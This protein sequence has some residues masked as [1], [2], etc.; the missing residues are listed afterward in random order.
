MDDYDQTTCSEQRATNRVRIK[1]FF[2]QKY[3]ENS[4]WKNHQLKYKQ[5]ILYISSFKGQLHNSIVLFGRSG[6]RP[7]NAKHGTNRFYMPFVAIGACGTSARLLGT[8][9]FCCPVQRNSRFYRPFLAFVRLRHCFLPKRAANAQ[10]A[11]S[12]RESETRLIAPS[13]IFRLS[14]TDKYTTASSGIR[15]RINIK[16]TYTC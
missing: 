6:V 15:T 14:K 10:I 16:R 1:S 3:S 7:L 5:I 11:R 4:A 2:R 8:T 12:W 13:G 9:R